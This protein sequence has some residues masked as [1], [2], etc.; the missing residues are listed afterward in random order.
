MGSV[1]KT[2]ISPCERVEYFTVKIT[3]I[4]AQFLHKIFIAFSMSLKIE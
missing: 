3:L 2:I 1:L 4:K